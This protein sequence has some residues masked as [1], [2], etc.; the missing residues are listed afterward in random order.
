MLLCESGGNE[1]EPTGGILE[2]MQNIAISLK[3]RIEAVS[4]GDGEGRH[5]L[6]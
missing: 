5:V 1:K 3:G 2:E 6:N 4:S